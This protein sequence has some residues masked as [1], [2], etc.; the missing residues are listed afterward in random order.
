[1]HNDVF[2]VMRWWRAL[3]KRRLRYT[4]AQQPASMWCMKIWEQKWWNRQKHKNVECGCNWNSNWKYVIIIVCVLHI[5]HGQCACCLTDW[6]D[7]WHTTL[8]H[9]L[10]HN[11]T[12]AGHIWVLCILCFIRINS[13]CVRAAPRRCHQAPFDRSNPQRSHTLL[14]S[15][16]G[17]AQ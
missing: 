1:M 15:D 17:F 14:Q 8:T 16:S 9:T 11:H 7:C 2:L 4:V 13:A 6:I 10:T 5:A 3:V 12:V